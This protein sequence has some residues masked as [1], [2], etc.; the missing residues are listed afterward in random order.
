MS[1][2]MLDSIRHV[3]GLIN[4]NTTSLSMAFVSIVDPFPLVSRMYVL[5][6]YLHDLSGVYSH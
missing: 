4:C 1:S 2:T 6:F 3:R 5:R